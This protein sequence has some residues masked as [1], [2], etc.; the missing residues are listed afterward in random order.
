M[1][2]RSCKVLA[3]GTLMGGT[4]RAGRPGAGGVPQSITSQ[5]LIADLLMTLPS[6][7]PRW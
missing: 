1:I 4:F 5:N 6:F 3:Y 2:G 7:M